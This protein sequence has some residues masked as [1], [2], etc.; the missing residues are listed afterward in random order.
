MAACLD[1]IEVMPAIAD[2]S[3][4]VLHEKSLNL[5]CS[6]VIKSGQHLMIGMSGIPYH[7]YCVSL[8]SL[9]ANMV[10][11]SALNIH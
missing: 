5:Y 9:T 10:V 1:L 8:V 11:S 2:L 6:C 7:C 3:V 4:N